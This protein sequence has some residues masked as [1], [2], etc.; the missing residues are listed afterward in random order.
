LTYDKGTPGTPPS[1]ARHKL[2]KIA[3][4]LFAA[5]GY[6]GTS[7][8]E[9]VERAG[10][11]KPVLYYHFQN[12]AGL[13]RAILDNA[14]EVQQ[15][16][17][18]EVMQKGGSTHARLAFL[19]RRIYEGVQEHRFLFR[20]I[21]N[22]VFGPPRGAPAYDLFRYYRNT[23]S[24]IEMIYREGLNAGEVFNADPEEAACLVLSLID[25]C[26]NIEQVNP[27]VADAKRPE[28][29]LHL[30]FQGLKP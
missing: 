17:L 3:S 28:R 13:F 11:S 25:F 30:A 2:M 15:Q 20:L 23:I 27:E 22:L 6:A 18:E 16:V 10:V 7:V 21:H 19:F 1:N 24:A 8:R 12:K 4:E 5:K 29:L 9:I 26:L 14:A